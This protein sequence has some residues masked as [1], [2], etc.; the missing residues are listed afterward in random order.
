LTDARPAAPSRSRRTGGAPPGWLWVA[1]AAVIAAGALF[2]YDRPWLA[3]EAPAFVRLVAGH[4]V[5]RDVDLSGYG[6]VVAMVAGDPQPLGVRWIGDDLYRSWVL[7][8]LAG[9]LAHWTHNALWSIYLLD[10]GAWWAAA[11]CTGRLAQRLGTSRTAG[12]VAAL[13]VAASPA[14][15]VNVWWNLF[16]LANTASLV[17][18]AYAI[19]CILD[20]LADLHDPG[21]GP[22]PRRI[23]IAG[24]ALGLVLFGTSLLYSYVW[25]VVPCFLAVSLVEAV[26]GRGRA[27]GAALLIWPISVGV[28]LALTRGAYALLAATG[29]GVFVQDDPMRR[30]V[31][32][33]RAITGNPNPLAAA[34]EILP[35][36]LALGHMATL[37]HPLVLAAGVAGIVLGPRRLRV[38]GATATLLA[39]VQGALVEQPWVVIN[40]YPFLY[41]GVGVVLAGAARQIET[42]ATW[43]PSGGA[44]RGA[45]IVLLAGATALLM[46]VTNLDVI[47]D[48][49]LVRDAWQWLQIPI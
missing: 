9:V 27:R 7:I 14:F 23:A 15:V 13:L 10:F 47:G 42:R 4:L 48:Y 41:A 16:H 44:R 21:G 8:Y 2:R 34:I 17:F 29:W 33:V 5:I 31:P 46:A 32:L 11:L 20:D 39:L 12:V 25:V 45:A 6:S 22:G 36:L 19:A 43:L 30:V 38:A 28:Y 49:R 3:M 40:N 37:F 24:G 18:S 26:A 1:T 35:G